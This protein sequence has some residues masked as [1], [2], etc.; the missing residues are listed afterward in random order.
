MRAC[1]RYLDAEWTIAKAEGHPRAV[2]ALGRVAY[3]AVRQLLARFGQPVPDRLFRHG[4]TH[5]SQDLLVVASFHPSP[6][7]TQTGRLKP[8]MLDDVLLASLD[9]LKIR[10]DPSGTRLG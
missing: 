4:A 8:E 3:G 7:N 2:V 9:W 1:S 6:Q 10:E 5:H